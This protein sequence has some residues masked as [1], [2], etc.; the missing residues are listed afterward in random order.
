M[1]LAL[2]FFFVLLLAACSTLPRIRIG[3]AEV[4]A[5]KDAGTPATLKQGETKTGMAIPPKTKVSI[6]KTEAIPATAE[7]P[8]RPAT[9]TLTFD[10][11]Q[12]SEFIQTAN[13]LAASTGTVDTSVA[14]KRIETESKAPLLWAGIACLGVGVVLFVLKWPGPALLCGIGSGAFFAAWKIA[15]IPWWAGLLAI[16]AAV[17]LVVGFLRKEKDLNGDGI[18]DRFQKINP[19]AS[20]Q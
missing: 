16:G 14:K 19:P 8:A 5:P 20:A 10:F 2:A 15:D 13:T 4:A 3:K 12:A 1:K 6:V 18:P 7:T 11:S 17:F 9:E